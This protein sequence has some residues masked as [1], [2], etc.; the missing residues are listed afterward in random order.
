MLY[1]GE[2]DWD[3]DG[4]TWADTE[5]TKFSV[6]AREAW[7]FFVRTSRTSLKFADTSVSFPWRRKTTFLLCS[8]SWS[9]F[10]CCARERLCNDEICWFRDERSC[11]MIEVNSLISTGRSSKSVF[12]L[13]T[14]QC[15]HAIPPNLP[16]ESRTLC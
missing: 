8:P 16:P 7:I 10:G 6:R 4:A 5:E 11:L 13:A 2:A 15:Q 14:V 12:L 1:N 3:I 9:A